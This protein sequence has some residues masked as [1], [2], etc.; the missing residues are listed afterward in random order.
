MR[1]AITM[2]MAMGL[3]AMTVGSASAHAQT[4]RAPQ[5]RYQAHIVGA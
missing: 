1:R 2:T 3:L 4:L 5:D